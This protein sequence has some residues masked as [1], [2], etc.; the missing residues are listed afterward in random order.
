MV[1]V[2][3]KRLCVAVSRCQAGLCYANA[4]R[5]LLVLLF[6]S[7]SSS[8]TELDF[9]IDAG[10]DKELGLPTQFYGFVIYVFH[11][12]VPV[13]FLGCTYELTLHCNFCRYDMIISV[14]LNNHSWCG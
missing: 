8:Y 13:Y 5:C 12:R 6:P 2:G 9:F 10:M 14:Y 4:L 7:D 3:G 11:S 1:G